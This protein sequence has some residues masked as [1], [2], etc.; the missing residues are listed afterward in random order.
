MEQDGGP[1]PREPLRRAQ[2]EEQRGSRAALKIFL[3]YAP[4][5]GKTHAMLESARRLVAQQVDV[6]V[7]CVEPHGR[8]ETSELAEGIEVLP[9]RAVLYRGT[10]LTEF[11]LDGALARRPRVLL[12][13][14]LAHTNAPGSRHTKRWQDAI[15]LLE[16]GIDVH[17]T[18]NVQHIES[19][20]DVVSQ[21]TGVRVR[22]TVPDWMLARADEIELV[23]P[24]PEVLLVRLREGKVYFPDQAYIAAD[25]FFRRGNLLALRELAL[26][27]AAEVLRQ[28][29]EHEATPIAVGKQAHSRWRD[30]LKVSLV[31][32]L[33]RGS[34]GVKEHF[35]TRDEVEQSSH[36]RTGPSR[37]QSDARG[38][39]LAALLVSIATVLASLVRAYI[40]QA[41]VVMIYL[42]T[43]MVVAY[44]WG[45][46]PSMTAAA[47]SVATYDFFFVPPF[48]TFAVEHS[49]HLL[50][51]AMMFTVGLVISSLTSRLR[52]EE[53]E[54]RM[55]EARTAA[56]YSLT[57]EL[58]A[59][60]DE[61]HAAEVTARHA[62]ELFEGEAAMLLGD[63]TGALSIRG[64][65]RADLSLTQ[66]E[67]AVVQWA[68]DHGRMAGEG[69]D[70]LPGTHLTCAPLQA[71]SARLGVLALRLP[72]PGALHVESRNLLEAFVRQA[73]ISIERARLAEE[74]KAAALRVRTEEM[75]SSLLSAVSHD[76][77]TPLAAITGAGT[78]L[79]D[80]GQRLRP[81]QREELFDTICTEAER[82][83]R[84]VGNILYMVRLESAGIVPK[85]DWVPLEEIVGSALARLDAKLGKRQVVLDIPQDLP[86]LSVDPVLFEQVFVNLIE[87]A[88]KYAGRESPIEVRA[89]TLEG[90]LEV[91]VADRGPGIPAGDE[92]RVFEK[93]Y[94]GS[95]AP[96]G[97]A[98][99]GLSI[100]RGI[101]QAHAGSLA[102]RNREDGGATFRMR[103]PLLEAPPSA[104]LVQDQEGTG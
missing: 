43:I 9:R 44:R 25:H 82:L 84:L 80:E 39:A 89:R 67:L 54:A 62:A 11:D 83:E 81:E 7:G 26:R 63:S 42:L 36:G 15:D 97:G 77:R 61:E 31:K 30:F 45:R 38:Y 64:K 100:C 70:T 74:A 60:P 88:I 24:P 35:I 20:N 23:N 47:L 22:E 48:F 90:T 69:T 41:D 8:P 59:V 1:N 95:H 102:A 104:V 75:R 52:R 73:A 37:K 14:E 78:A 32:E 68:S 76:L 4:G 12:L 5:V 53:R 66:E 49:R 13:D 58:A 18:L 28:A 56:L 55:R 33:L 98:G 2:A 19:L 10:S 101:L 40:S 93:F 87:N 21:I 57:G 91:E 3:G 72:S 27:R 16:A 71:G 103:V 17:T 79:R 51:F 86:L 50:T 99:L 34:S 94:R 6:L 92:E 46:G 65:S 29:R 96:G 85:R